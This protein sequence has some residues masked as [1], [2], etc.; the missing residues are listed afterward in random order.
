MYVS[1]FLGNETLRVD[2]S[3]S[4]GRFAGVT[5]SGGGCAAG[6]PV[7]NVSNKHREEN[8]EVEKKDFEEFDSARYNFVV[9]SGASTGDL[10]GKNAGKNGEIREEEH[11]SGETDPH[12]QAL[13]ETKEEISGRKEVL[14]IRRRD[15]HHIYLSSSVP[16]SSVLEEAKT[17]AYDTQRK[18]P[19]PTNGCGWLALMVLYKIISRWVFV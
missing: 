7:M 17:A 5:I 12:P 8:E 4:G 2:F 14:D 1:R 15:G 10:P 19:C 16:I 18:C 6:D 13:L 3:L 11:P 9:D